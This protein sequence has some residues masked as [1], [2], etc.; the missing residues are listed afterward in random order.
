M[1]VPGPPEARPAPVTSADRDLD[2][3]LLR[4]VRG[5]DVCAWCGYPVATLERWH[6]RELS[7]DG[8]SRVI[9]NRCVSEFLW[10]HRIRRF[11]PLAFGEDRS[12]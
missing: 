10:R 8:R 11:P 4:P 6:H 12:R 2:E 9:C 3:R 1:T 7:P 5:S